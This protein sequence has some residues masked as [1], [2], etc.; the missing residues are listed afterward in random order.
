MALEADRLG[1]ELVSTLDDPASGASAVEESWL[2]WVPA[3]RAAAVVSLATGR[4][5]ADWDRVFNLADRID[6]SDPAR[7]D[8]A[9]LRV[10][11]NLL[12]AASGARLEAD[13]WPHLRGLTLGLL[14]DSARPGLPGPALLCLHLDQEG[15][16]RRLLDEVLPRLATLREGRR[17]T[18]PAPGSSAP[19]LDP[20]RARSL[21]RIAGRPLEALAR[22][23]TVVIG[24]GDGALAASQQAA[25][26][27]D[28]VRAWLFPEGAEAG[29]PRPSRIGVIWPGRLSL[30][31]AGLDGPSPLSSA[32]AAGPPIVWR[33]WSD[34]KQARDVVQWG[35]LD[36]LVRR[37]LASI[38][39][40][41]RQVP[42]G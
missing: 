19:T 35:G 26:R 24:W 33:G 12:A 9:P 31:V 22:G 34:G 20:S 10:R 39:P 27:P 41:S 36:G 2:S 29:R 1:L 5:P 37:F 28:A 23:T 4:T 32:L 6:R 15:A 11:L 17:L 38:P 42:W 18:A 40:A 13:L 16:A 3:E 7:A 14:V 25:G 30:P 21:G 8:L